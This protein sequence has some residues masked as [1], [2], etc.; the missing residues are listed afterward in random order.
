MQYAIQPYNVSYET[1]TI[2]SVSVKIDNSADIVAS[3]EKDDFY[4]NFYLQ[5]SGTDYANWA[6]DDNY[7]VDWVCTQ[8]G[9]TR[10]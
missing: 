4:Q 6:A 5:M 1:L 2:E 9:L 7:V 8:L 10:A 3:V